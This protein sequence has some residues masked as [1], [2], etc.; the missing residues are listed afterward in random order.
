M[1]PRDWIEPP[2]P[3]TALRQSTAASG[4]VHHAAK[5]ERTLGWILWI[6]LAVVLVY[7][8]L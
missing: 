6:G 5:A 3:L 1:N 4:Y 8:S 2:D 7:S